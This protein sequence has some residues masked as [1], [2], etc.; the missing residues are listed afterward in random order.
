M[1]KRKMMVFTVA[2]DAQR[3]FLSR[4]RLSEGVGQAGSPAFLIESDS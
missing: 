3:P 2:E 1:S 4:L